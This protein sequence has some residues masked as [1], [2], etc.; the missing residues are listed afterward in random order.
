MD[1]KLKGT[2]MSLGLHTGLI[3]GVKAPGEDDSLI[4][5]LKTLKGQG[6]TRGPTEQKCW[7]RCHNR[8][9]RLQSQRPCHQCRCGSRDKTVNPAPRSWALDSWLSS[10]NKDPGS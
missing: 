5:V 9:D 3:K 7:E 8:R 4:Q 10:W 2:I 6:G 1:H